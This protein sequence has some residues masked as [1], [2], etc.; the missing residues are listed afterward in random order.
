M[1]CSLRY[2]TNIRSEKGPHKA[3]ESGSAVPACSTIAER[4]AELRRRRVKESRRSF[5]IILTV[6]ISADPVA[7]CVGVRT[8]FSHSSFSL[9][10]SAAI[11]SRSG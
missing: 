3:Y 10:S 1:E 5:F 8:S 11:A 6:A 9:S 7:L 2:T 4:L